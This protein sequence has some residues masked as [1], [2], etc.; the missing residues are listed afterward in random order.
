MWGIFGL[1]WVY[2]VSLAGSLRSAGSMA[3]SAGSAI[4]Q[5]V[6]EKARALSGSPMSQSQIVQASD[7]LN[8][9]IKKRAKNQIDIEF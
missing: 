3:T 1:Y 8:K 7:P 6:A 2:F 4:I 5:K 9:K